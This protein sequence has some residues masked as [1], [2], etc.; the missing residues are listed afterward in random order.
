MGGESDVSLIK[1]H[2]K[3]YIGAYPGKLVMALKQAK[4]ENPVILLDEI[5]KV[6]PGYRGNIQD[7][8]LEVLDPAQNHSFRDNFLEAPLDLSKVLFVS[9]A[10][11][12]DTISE[13][14]LDRLEVIEL[15]GYTMNEKLSIA[16]NYLIPKTIKNKGLEGYKV[17]IP[18]ETLSFLIERYAREAGVRSL[19]KRISRICEKICLKIV[20][21]GQKEFIV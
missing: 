5:D 14:L 7:T 18:A 6:S 3:T 21:T 1:G 12:L 10:N 19:E 17:E 9:S 15:S 13:P 8:L 2:R 20:E 4:T 16:Q 11:L